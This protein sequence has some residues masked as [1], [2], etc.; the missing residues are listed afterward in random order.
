[1]RIKRRT[2]EILEVASPG[3]KASGVFDIFIIA[4]IA[5]NVI[6]VI[7]G[8]IQ[9][10]FVQHRVFFRRFEVF[11]VIVFTLEY[12]LRVWSCTENPKY[13][14]PI[15]GR[16]RFMITPLALIDLFAVL[17]FYLPMMIKLDLRFLR[18]V[19]LIRIF[20]LFK[21]GRYSESMR[22]FGRVLKAKKEQLVITVFAVFI[23]LIVASSL[24]YYVETEAQPEAFSSIPATMWWGV[25]ALTTVGYGDMYP[26]TPIGKFLGAIISLLGIGL[27]AMPTGILSA[28]FVE[29]IK[30]SKERKKT[31]PSCGFELEE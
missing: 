2:Y 17:P 3:D 10:L 15:L 31:C 22:I 24:L 29:E 13:K 12:V 19:R 5:L 1:M 14:N 25:S 23:L 30:K 26:I 16:L 4:L 6:A 21:V 28:G 7:L 18:A 27:F 8:T 9:S 11:S 20:R